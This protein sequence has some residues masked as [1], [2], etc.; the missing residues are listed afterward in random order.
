MLF[1]KE[2]EIKMIINARLNSLKEHI[3][4]KQY[5]SF[6]RLPQVL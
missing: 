2:G 5:R 1:K 4:K 3:R 6:E